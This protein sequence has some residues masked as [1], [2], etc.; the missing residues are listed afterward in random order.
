MTTAF[1]TPIRT[2]GR[3]FGGDARLRS[4]PTATYIRYDSVVDPF[5]E[6]VLIGFDQVFAP[7]VSESTGAARPADIA[8]GPASAVAVVLDLM[9][10]LGLSQKDILNAA[11]IRKRT[12]QDWHRNPTRQ[13]RLASQADLWALAQSVDV[14]ADSLGGDLERWLKA[15]H[16]RIKMLRRGDHR[17]LVRLATKV[18]VEDSAMRTAER[19]LGVGFFDE[20]EESKRRVPRAGTPA[21]GSAAVRAQLRREKG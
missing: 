1:A 8:S 11:G 2:G 19:L 17:E 14:M 6:V 5:F 13:P 15:D 7:E 16:E 20:G 12:F 4:R 3:S 9:A 18:E 21:R 10:R